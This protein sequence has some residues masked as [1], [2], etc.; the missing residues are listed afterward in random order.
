MLY[1]EWRE[2][3]GRR[4]SERALRDLASG[5]SW[6]FGEL[7]DCSDAARAP[8]ESILFP[9][10]QGEEFILEVL[11]AWRH[12]CC[13]CPLESDQRP[14]A[15]PSPPSDI[16][17]LKLTSATTGPARLV[18]FKAAQLAADPANIVATMG[19]RPE[20]PNLGAI[21]LAHSYGFSNLVLPLLRQGIPLVLAASALPEAL[22]RAAEGEPALTLAGVPAL[23]R[24]WHEAHAIPDGVRLA[25]SAG[26][27]LPLELER[28]VFNARG[29]KIHNFYGSSECGG[30][31]YDRSGEPRSD[32]GSVGT[33]M[34]GVSLEVGPDGCLRVLGPN[35]AE[36]YWPEPADTLGNGCFQTSDLAGFR[37][38]E[39]HLL[40][41]AGD[42]INVAGRKVAPE[43]VEQ[44]LRRH[45]AVRDCVVFG[46]PSGRAERGE[47]IV[48]V[49]VVDGAT[50][51]PARL[52]AFASGS[53]SDWQIPRGWWFVPSLEVDARGKISR[54]QWRERYRS[55]REARQAR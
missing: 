43:T 44:V 17:H 49:V 35:V 19:L 22:R 46:V 26:A 29:L 48:A 23:W 37:G 42:V 5:R 1:D 40:G 2:M 55:R 12:G 15:V 9:R 21:S 51:K 50:V 38:R 6:T 20:W 54:R 7:L 3:A 30:I 18:A 13:V 28:E 10:G 11:R 25:I 39:L 14:L 4:R 33:P 52:A 45:E 27:P 41:R 31:A 32:S 8:E 47:C 34:E 24:V 36:T 53:L 16:V